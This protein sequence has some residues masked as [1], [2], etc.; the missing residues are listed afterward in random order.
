[1]TSWE[2]AIHVIYTAWSRPVTVK[3]DFAREHAE[4]LVWAVS[5]GYLT[6]EIAP[7]TRD[8]GNL[9]KATAKGLL[10]LEDVLDG[11]SREEILGILSNGKA[12]QENV[13]E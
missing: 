8:Y 9:Y 1:M 7:F 10:F 12:G 11:L 3:S 6:T 2:Q 13:W 4:C 5:R